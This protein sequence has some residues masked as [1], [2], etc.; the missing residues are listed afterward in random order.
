ML[1]PPP[2]ALGRS[3]TLDYLVAVPDKVFHG[4][5][6]NFCRRVAWPILNYQIPDSPKDRAYQDTSWD[7]YTQMNQ[8]FARVIAH[9]WNSGDCVWVHDYHLALV[10]AML[11]EKVPDACIGFFLHCVFPSSEVFRCLAQR[12]Y[13]LQGLLGADLIGFQTEEHRLNFVRT[14]RRLL[15]VE[16]RQDMI[17]AKERTVRVRSFPIGID[18]SR[19][20][21]TLQS[22]HVKNWKNQV[23]REY[24][25]KS[26]VVAR[27]R[28]D[29]VSGLKEKL[30]AYE[31]FLSCYPSWVGKVVL[32][33]IGLPS[34][35]S[36]GLAEEL[37][38]IVTRIN[39]AHASVTYQPLI[40]FTHDISYPQY[41]ALLSAA[42]VATVFG[43]SAFLVNPWDTRQCAQAIRDALELDTDEAEQR[44]QT[45]YDTVQREGAV[46]WCQLFL[47]TLRSNR[48]ER[49]ASPGMTGAE[50]LLP[51]I[52]T[53]LRLEPQNRRL[54]IVD[55]DVVADCQQS[56]A[57]SLIWSMMEDLTSSIQ[58]TVYMTST[59]LPEELCQAF[60]D[61]PNL[62]LIA[63]HGCMVKW[64]GSSRWDS[65]HG[66]QKSY[67]YTSGVASILAYFQERT[68]G[69]WVESRQCSFVFH[70]DSSW[71]FAKRQAAC[72][73]DEVHGCYGGQ[74]IQV[75]LGPDTVTIS[76]AGVDL[77]AAGQ[78]V[79]HRLEAID[80]KGCFSGPKTNIILV[81]GGAEYES[82]FQWGSGLD[83]SEIGQVTMI[84]SGTGRTQAPW[85]L[86]GTMTGVHDILQFLTSRDHIRYAP[87][88]E[89]SEGSHLFTKRIASLVSPE[90]ETEYDW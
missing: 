55:E 8:A 87:G 22:P 25:D 80:D 36:A 2:G 43:Q 48:V 77:G 60:Q 17:Y 56:E 18:A 70:Y 53:S 10:P 71:S 83:R 42:N 30:L 72:L 78:A 34:M 84:H 12:N 90:E 46:G 66:T 40:F 5:Y 19:L 6:A 58:N 20:N 16:T 68:P 38:R 76:P 63:D 28:L 41:L 33:Q 14:C 62:G 32:V 52:L 9:N 61:N 67:R 13:I 31:R 27:D 75:L 4:H 79:L 3:K 88:E 50:S 59:R 64:A 1:C 24:G 89:M 51:E 39:S 86:E 26:L 81:G 65:V 21:H 69:S 23:T 73:S 29:L 57:Q 11:R 35:G 54:I 45:I 82:L 7:E 44:C 15:H 49:V 37:S 47:T 85:T 74:I